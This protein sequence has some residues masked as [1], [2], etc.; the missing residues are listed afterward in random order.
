MHDILLCNPLS[1]FSQ[2]SKMW[3]KK[4]E[5][6]LLYVIFVYFSVDYYASIERLF[7]LIIIMHLS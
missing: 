1:Y 5:K 4:R 7:A 3:I 6:E 2:E